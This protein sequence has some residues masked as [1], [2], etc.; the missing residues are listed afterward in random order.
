MLM[1]ALLLLLLLQVYLGGFASEEDA[2][3][4]YDRAAIAYWGESA[5]T[6]VSWHSVQGFNAATCCTTPLLLTTR[7][8]DFMLLPAV[9]GN[10]AV[11]GNQCC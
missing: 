3:R 11:H 9:P 7:G 1:L 8:A 6:N 4:A 10:F 2:A 5:T